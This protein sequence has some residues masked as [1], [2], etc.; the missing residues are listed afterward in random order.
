MGFFDFFKKK[1]KVPAPAAEKAVEIDGQEKYLLEKELDEPT[2]ATLTVEEAVPAPAPKA[3]KKATKSA[4]EKV[5]SATKKETA[6]TTEGAKKE[7]SKKNTNTVIKKVAGVTV[8]DEDKS[9][10]SKVITPKAAAEPAPVGADADT[11]DGEILESKA[12]RSGKFELKR[13]KDGRFFFNLY[14]SNHTVIAFSQIY[15]SS[16]SALNGIKSV[17]ANAGVANTE[18]TTLK[19][20]VSVQFPK[21][22]IYIDKA[23]QYRFRLYAPN[24]NC[25]CHAAH[26]Y[27]TKANCKGGIE[28][29]IRFAAE[30][31]IDKKYLVK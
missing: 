17:M 19:N 31:R 12:T 3:E 21:W 4:D 15:S 10:E 29:I 9:S 8:E 11:E 20:P 25:V 2:P 22:E 27:T 30:S 1:K 28:S 24:G 16:S 7:S 23:N 14:A 13:A 5:E 6:K 26:G 18:D